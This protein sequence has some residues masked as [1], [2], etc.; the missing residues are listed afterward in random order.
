M[1]TNIV[2]LPLQQNSLVMSAQTISTILKRYN[3]AAPLPG[4][5]ATTAI[6]KLEAFISWADK[7][8]QGVIKH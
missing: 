5:P 6:P 2:P 4:E 1:Q 8:L 7:Q 3:F